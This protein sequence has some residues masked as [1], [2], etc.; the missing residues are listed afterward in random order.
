VI[1][2]PVQSPRCPRCGAD[3]VERFRWRDGNLFWGC[4]QYPSCRGT[5]PWDDQR[6]DPDPRGPDDMDLGQKD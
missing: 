6:F 1:G 5:Y 4:S 3:M 2:D